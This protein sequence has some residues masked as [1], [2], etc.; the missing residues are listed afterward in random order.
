MHTG[1]K[2]FIGVLFEVFEVIFCF[3]F[4]DCVAEQSGLVPIIWC[5]GV[6]YSADL[7]CS[8]EALYLAE[9]EY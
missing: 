7:L 6:G 9:G 2:L 3:V 1:R 5:P 8:A 4:E